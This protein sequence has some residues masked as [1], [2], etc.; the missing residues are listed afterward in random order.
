LASL[1]ETPI[2]SPAKTPVASP[3]ETALPPQSPTSIPGQTVVPVAAPPGSGNNANQNQNAGFF[4]PSNAGALGGIAAGIAAALALIAFFILRRRRQGADQREPLD[5]EITEDTHLDSDYFA[6]G[7]AKFVS[8]YGLSEEGN[9]IHVEDD[10]DVISDEMIQ[11]QD[12]C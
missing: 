4:D 8:E 5:A 6:E 7:D 10:N 9:E 12:E 11:D 1:K 2:A 3:E